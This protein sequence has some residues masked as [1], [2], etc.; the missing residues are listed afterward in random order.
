MAQP[1]VDRLV[2]QQRVEHER[3]RPQPGLEPG[4]DRLGRGAAHLAVGR[5]QLRQALL[6]AD[7]LAVEVDGDR[8]RELAEQ[9]RPRTAPGQR[10][11]GEDPLLG[12]AEQVRPVAAGRLEVVAAERERV[13]GEQR[14]GPVVGQRRPLE[15]DEEQLV[16]DRGR[17]LLGA[18]H[19]RADRG[20]GGVD[21]EPQAR[22]TTRP[23]PPAR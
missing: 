19:Q 4:G 9:A 3:P 5:H 11:V 22:R 8:R 21:R 2:G 13:V 6:E 17:A 23:D 12:L 14:V 15:L 10:L 1:V 18:G 7:R 20:V 16:G